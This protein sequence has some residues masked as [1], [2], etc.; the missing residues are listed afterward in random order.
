MSLSINH[1]VVV[2]Y[3]VESG[4]QHVERALMVAGVESAIKGV[5]HALWRL[6]KAL[7]ARRNALPA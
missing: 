4:R 5:D 2:G 3:L 1:I 7:L 6:D